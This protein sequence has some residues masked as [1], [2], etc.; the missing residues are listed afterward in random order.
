MARYTGAKCKRCR[1]EGEKL[2]LKGLKCYGP[3]CA[4]EKAQARP[5]RSRRGRRRQQGSE[6]GIQLREKQKLKRMYGVYE[7]QFRRYFA[8]A[9]RQ[10]GIVAENLLS[11]LERRLDNVVFRSG[12]SVSRG[13]ARQLVKHGHVMVNERKVDIPSYLV[14]AGDVI[15]IA[16]KSREH[17]SVREGLDTV[18]SRGIPPWLELDPAR[19]EGQVKTLPLGDQVQIP[20]RVQLVVGLYTR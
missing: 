15:S 2:F 16:E 1:A 5:T 17:I 6:Y 4:L 10:K 9:E 3:K 19:F 14:K 20:V 18:E 13:V 12:L 11:L 7:R 8:L